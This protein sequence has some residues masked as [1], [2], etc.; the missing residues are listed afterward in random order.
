MISNQKNV[1]NSKEHALEKSHL[2]I[3]ECVISQDHNNDN[4]Y[5]PNYIQE[6]HKQQTEM[7]TYLIHAKKAGQNKYN[8][9]PKM[10]MS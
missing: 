6:K 3:C 8:Q 5:V 2:S 4:P 1:Y 10:R 9:K 7:T